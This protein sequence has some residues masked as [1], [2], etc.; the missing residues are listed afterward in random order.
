MKKI[1]IEEA[2]NLNRHERRKLA[3]LNGV[4]KIPSQKKQSLIKKILNKIS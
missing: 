3:K 4:P 1:S 2:M